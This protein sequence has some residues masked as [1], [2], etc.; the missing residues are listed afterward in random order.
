MPIYTRTGDRGATGLGSN[1]RVP[2]TDPRI[3]AIGTLDELN[4]TLGVSISL[5][6]P[7]SELI[8]ELGIIQYELFVLGAHLAYPPGSN[9]TERGRL[10][11]FPPE[12]VKELETQINQWWEKLPP[13]KNFIL[14]GG[15][16]AAAHLHTARTIAR[17]A[18]RQLVALRDHDPD[19]APHFLE[20][21][22]RLSDWL[23]TAA[24]LANQEAGGTETIWKPSQPR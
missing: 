7:Q 16:V 19:I 24:R 5:L 1:Q 10:P 14:P 20:W 2:K 21:L 9:E 6:P 18:E 15:S 13:L 22:N 17:R 3:E 12:K 11:H 8:E 23:F 4:A